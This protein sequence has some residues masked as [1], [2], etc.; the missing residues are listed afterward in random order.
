MTDVPRLWMITCERI[1]LSKG[2]YETRGR[3]WG[4][5]APLYRI[6]YSSPGEACFT[7][8]YRAE[9]AKEARAMFAVD[10]VKE[11]QRRSAEERRARERLH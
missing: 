9:S 10:C 8:E 6:T 11:I 2:G 4:V 7:G 5:G 3:Y 1:R